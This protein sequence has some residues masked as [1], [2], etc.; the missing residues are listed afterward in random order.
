MKK[1]IHSILKANYHLV[2]FFNCKLEFT[3]L[4]TFSD[5]IIYSIKNS[6]YYLEY[7]RKNICFYAYRIEPVYCKSDIKVLG[8]HSLNLAMDDIEKTLRLKWEYYG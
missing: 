6:K 4:D 1:D 7:D 5:S 8:I 3:Y 2:E